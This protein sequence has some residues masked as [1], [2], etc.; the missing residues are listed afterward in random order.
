MAR[1]SKRKVVEQTPPADDGD[2]TEEESVQMDSDDDI[3]PIIDKDSDDEDGSNADAPAEEESK[4][5]D[6]SNTKKKSKKKKSDNMVEAKKERIIPFMD[7]FYH[8]SS[9]DSPKDRS[10]AARDLIHHCFLTGKGVNQKDAAYALTRLMNGLCTGRAASRQGF[11]SCLSSFLRVAYSSSDGSAIEELLNEDDFAKGLKKEEHHFATTIRLKLLSTTQILAT[12]VNKSGK[13]QKKNSFGG[14]MKGIEERDHIYGRLFGILAVVRSGML[15]LKDLPPTVIEGYAK[16]LVDLYHHKKWMREPSVH[17]LIELLSA[18]DTGSNVELI[19]QVANSVI[20]PTLLLS[21]GNAS[22]ADRAQFLQKLSPEQIAVALHLQTLQKNGIKYDSP[23]DKPLLTAESIPTLSAALSSTSDVVHPRSHVVWNTL[24]MYLTEEN[25][26]A[27]YRQLKTNEGFPEVIEKIIQCVVIEMLLGK[28]KG[29]SQPTNERRSLALQIICTL[30]GSSDLKITLPLDLIGHVLCP[31]VVTGVLVNVLCASGGAGKKKSKEAVQH[32]LKPF[33][34]KMLLDLIDHCCENDD[35]DR[36]MAFAK[37]FILADPRFDTKTKSQTIASLLMLE[38]DDEETS[39]ESESQRKA[40]WQRYL[41]FLE[42]KIVL[43]SSLHEAT[44]YIELMFKLARRDLAKA[45]ADDARRVVRFFMSGAFFDCSYLT[46][47][48][49]AQKKSST[50]KKK[51]KSKAAAS[52]PNPPQE[53]SSGLRIKEMLE[54][55]GRTSILPSARGIMAARFH[56]LLS[57]FVSAIN[58]QNRGGNKNKPFY[59]KGSKPESIYRALSEVSGILSL[60]ESSGAK[61]FVNTSTNSETDDAS[62]MEDP[63]EASRASLLQVQSIANDALVNECDGSGDKDVLRAKAVF[64]TGCASLMMSLYLQLS[65]CGNDNEEED[66]EDDDVFESVHEY[67]SDLAECVDGFCQVMENENSLKKD[68][69]EGNPLAAMAGLL[70]NILSSPVGGEDSGKA[71]PVRSSASKLTRE[72]VKVA[73]SGMISV[74]NDLNEKNKTLKSLV[75]ED[76]MS[77]LIESVCGEKSMTDDEH[78][79]DESIDESDSSEDELGAS[80]VFANASEAGMDLDEVNE[81]PASDSEESNE[82]SDDGSSKDSEDED[83]GK[84]IELDPEKLENLL[85]EDSD[86]EMSDSGILEHHAGADKALAQL[87]KLK[88]EARKKSQVERERVEICNRIRCAVLLDS[89]FSP[90]VFN[91]G[92]LPVEAVLGSIVPILRSRKAIAKSIQALSPINTKKSLGERE[93]L[94]ERLSALVKDKISKFRCSKHPEAEEVALKASSEIYEEMKLSLNNAH[95]S[96]CSIALITAVRC[97]P[98]LEENGAIRDIYASAVVDWSSRKATK[99][100]ECV[101]NDLIKRMPSLASLVLAKPLMTAAREAHSPFLKCESIKLMAALYKH[102]GT[103]ADELM[104]KQAISTLKQCCSKAAETLKNALED[105]SL[106]KAKHQD[107]VLNTTRHFVN[108]VKAQNEGILT[109]AELSGLQKALEKAGESQKGQKGKQLFSQI[110]DTIKTLARLDIGE[111]QK[112]KH[113]KTPKVPKSSKK[114]K[115]SKK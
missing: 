113:P 80:A 115:K 85:L 66:D 16:D 13:G 52:H 98:S 47:P 114:Q 38:N 109:N 83:G 81:D 33:T 6:K 60:L 82:G 54:E 24:W 57:D 105:S 28:G 44:V 45:P 70:V 75:D 30:S 112:P 58:S 72:T 18:L 106:Q 86:A 68:D 22:K 103:N 71:T 96:C 29:Q 97:V 39:E 110:S 25:N 56:S 62:D 95:C 7:T 64:V 99:I 92:W 51:T 11:A 53:L 93:G 101:F 36:R 77:I 88:Q 31:D 9:E 4:S 90:S 32:H 21:A 3:P 42:E 61:P 102:D 34:S 50:K 2:A 19:A 5:S 89:L 17:G 67:I 10:V 14:K 65:D 79:E 76:V 15:G 108:Y 87:I 74:I 63:M 37:A 20:T 73:W 104:S 78:D 8:L 1:K 12:D 46:D 100:H 35:I 107:E 111:G 26:S 43:A 59:A 23:L 69:D 84:D 41:S 91:S 55:N 94:L 40:I 27:G 49:A 48:S